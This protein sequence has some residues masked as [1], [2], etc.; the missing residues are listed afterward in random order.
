MKGKL[1]SSCRLFAGCRP[2][3][4]QLAASLA[5]ERSFSPGDVLEHIGGQVRELA[6]ISKGRC[7]VRKHT[8]VGRAI[9]MSRLSTGDMFGAVTLFDRGDTPMTE[10][11][12]L[13]PCTALFFSEAA[14]RQLLGADSTLVENYLAYLC[15]RIRFLN[16]RIDVFTAGTAEQR[17]YGWL[18]AAE[19]D[20]AAPIV[21]LTKLAAIL[22]IG[23]ASLY[24]AINSLTERGCIEKDGKRLKILQPYKG[25]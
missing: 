24:R 20:G 16:A 7:E 5:D 13:S 15:E 11:Y 17:L 23:R 10:V 25:E 9:V 4:L 8:T 18:A 12:A 22:D 21:S 1:I 6:I 19:Q 14:M 2:D 3:T